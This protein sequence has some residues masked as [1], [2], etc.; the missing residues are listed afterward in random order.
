MIT[1]TRVA[2]HQLAANSCQTPTSDRISK[3]YIQGKCVFKYDGK[4]IGLQTV[5]DDFI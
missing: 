2:P 3:A 1:G 4:G 5:N